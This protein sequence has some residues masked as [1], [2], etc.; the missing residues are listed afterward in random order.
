MPLGC[1]SRLPH[2]DV[3]QTAMLF[4]LRRLFLIF[5]T[6]VAIPLL[7]A[8]A[9]TLV[10]F[11]LL[12]RMGRLFSRP[13]AVASKPLSGLAS[14]II[15][16]WNGKDLLAEGL[17]TVLEAVREDQRPHEVIVVDNGSTDGSLQFVAGNFPEVRTVALPENHGFAAGNNA[18]VRA[19]RNDVVVLLNNDMLVHRDF[20]RPLLD[21][22]RACTFAVS[23]QIFHQDPSARREE[24]GK[25]AAFFRRGMID[26]EHSDVDPDGH[27]RPYYPA[28]WAG[29]GSSAFHRERFLSLGGFQ[30][31]YSPAYVEDTDLSYRAWKAGWEVRFAPAS[32]VYHKH[33]AST[34]RR[35]K[36]AQLQRLIL[37]N[38]LIFL[39]KNIDSWRLL[40]AHCIWLP[41]NLYRLAR[42]YGPGILG[43]FLQ[44]AVRLPAVQAAKV[45]SHLSAARR[46]GEIFAAFS[47]P[48][49]YFSHERQSWRS[50][51]NKAGDHRPAVLWVTAYLP[52]LGRHAGAARMHQLLKRI[53]QT[54]RV[55]LLSFL[56]EEEE[57]EFVPDLESFCESVIALRRV[58]PLRW[59]PFAYEPFEEFRTPDMEKAL[60]RCL[61]N[62][63]FDLI[64]LEYTQMAI[65]GDRQLRIPTLLTKHEV[66]FAACGRRARLQSNPLR[67][68]RWFYNYL[69][70]LDREMALMRRV[71]AAIC[72]TDSDERELKK[73]C[74]GTPIH[75]INTGV[76]LDYFRPPAQPAGNPTLVF[77]GAFRHEP[78]VDAMVHFCQDIF[79]LIRA[80]VRQARL[81]IVGSSPPPVVEGL[82]N[83]SG[84]EVT[85]FV[86]D[87]RPLMAASAVYVVPLRLGVGIRG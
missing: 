29:G 15:L 13:A 59:Q 51:D 8:L 12:A 78:N 23:S 43:S 46:D 75:V 45:G 69:Q 5:V 86:P 67:K 81:L 2:S 1:G 41:W 21:G 83:L 33:R 63:D 17:P 71:D 16:N 47:N 40:V 54:Y 74:N 35:F 68:L 7:I 19:A 58:P 66:D 49:R 25:T 79:P 6:V 60:R 82:A 27:P 32:I 85:G 38:Q 48:G 22:F 50:E 3:C 76:D 72:M 30:E 61:E 11:N 37:R 64:Q 57:R 42:D 65:Y 4:L 24:T 73:F 39:W 31:V 62:H 36:A 70:V 84:V 20:L 77:V 53:A 14:I 56:E 52:H 34:N 9:A 26:Y 55:T 18:G 10:I 44:A 80:Q 87:I 28:F